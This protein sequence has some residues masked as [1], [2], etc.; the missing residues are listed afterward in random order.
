[1]THH[2]AFLL[3]QDDLQSRDVDA[4]QQG[5]LAPLSESMANVLPSCFAVGVIQTDVRRGQFSGLLTFGSLP[6]DWHPSFQ[7]G[8]RDITSLTDLLY[9][10]MTMK[11]REIHPRGRTAGRGRGG[12]GHGVCISV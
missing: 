2:E 4:Q 6:V 5:G 9:L 12:R 7:S 8:L 11:N 3:R 10:L 1:M